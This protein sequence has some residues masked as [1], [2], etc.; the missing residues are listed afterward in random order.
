MNLVYSSFGEN[1]MEEAEN[2]SFHDIQS[3]A[4]FKIIGC[5]IAGEDLVNILNTEYHE[6]F[7]DL[8][9]VALNR[10]LRKNH[11]GDIEHF[12]DTDINIPEDDPE[13]E[14]TDENEIEGEIEEPQITLKDRLDHFV[15]KIKNVLSGRVEPDLEEESEK[16]HEAEDNLEI[17]SDDEESNEV[18]ELTEAEELE[19]DE[20]FEQD[21]D[22]EFEQDEDEEFVQDEDE[23]FEQD[24]DEEFVQDE[25]EE[26]DQND[27]PDQKDLEDQEY[28]SRAE[29]EMLKAESIKEIEGIDILFLFCSL[30]EYRS[31]DN[32]E[33]VSKTAHDLKVLNITLIELPRKFTK[34]DDVNLANRVLQKLRLLADIVVV[35]PEITKLGHKYVVQAVRGL[36]KLIITPGLVNLD[37]ADLKIIVKGGNVALLGFGEARG[38]NKMKKALKQTF[39][40]PLLQI[41]LKS[42]EKALVNVTGGEDMTIGEAEGISSALRKRIK[43]KSRIIL[44]ATVDKKRRDEINIM[45][46][47]GAT[48]M[49][50]LI[51]IYSKS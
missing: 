46:M 41:D 6:K 8:D 39:N 23:E 2:D 9:I 11:I 15:S 29:L 47:V 14:Q 42:V 1:S 34:I 5:G 50:V 40:S 37:F 48:P 25:D 13:L 45:V 19:P 33:I 30:E 38:E 44:G 12:I 27:E 26:L 24:E 3:L 16:E 51:D 36:L 49:Q 18:P 4:K 22:E 7:E 32:A 43:P 35:I 20:E 28:D 17:P 31:L 10:E 21:E